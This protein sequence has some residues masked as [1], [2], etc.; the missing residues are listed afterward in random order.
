[1]APRLTRADWLSFGLAAAALAA[2][3]AL[4]DA[5]PAEM[6]I[7]FSASGTPDNYVSKPLAVAVVPVL[8]V[9]TVLFME[10]AGRFDP[11]DDPRVLDVVKVATAGLLVAVQG[12]VLAWNLGYDV[13]FGLFLAGIAVWAVA[14][15]GYTVARERGARPL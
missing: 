15:V 11:P 4:W 6:A 2:G 13:P 5:L 10:A 3:L 1:M 7:H 14:V 8:T 9:A 12:F